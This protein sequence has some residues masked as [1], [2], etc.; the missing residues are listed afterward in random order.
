MIRRALHVIFVAIA[1]LTMLATARGFQEHDA[2]NENAAKLEPAMKQVEDLLGLKFKRP[3][4]LR[5]FDPDD[6]D[7]QR[8]MMQLAMTGSVHV[9]EFF[10]SPDES[11]AGATTI[12]EDTAAF[13]VSGSDEVSVERRIFDA[14]WGCWVMS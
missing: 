11:T 5:A 7:L 8:Q 4:S 2:R 3:V 9:L 12:L 6:P 14:A 1:L 10:E 13:Y